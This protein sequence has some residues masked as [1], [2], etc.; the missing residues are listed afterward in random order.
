MQ[1]IIAARDA[2]DAAVKE[3]NARADKAISSARERCRSVEAEARTA[4]AKA[5]ANW[6]KI[7]STEATK[8]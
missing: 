4:I 6:K 3:A 5:E 2:K 1:A 7:R 8:L